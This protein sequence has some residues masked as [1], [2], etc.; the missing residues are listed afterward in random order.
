MELI[1]EIEDDKYTIE[2]YKDGK[3]YGF[4]IFKK[5]ICP[6][7]RESINNIESC[8]NYHNTEDCKREVLNIVNNNKKRGE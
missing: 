1:E 6:C 7:G 2:I 4:K 3:Y 5:E 8:W